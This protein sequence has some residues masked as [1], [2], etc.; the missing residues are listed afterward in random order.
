MSGKGEE[1]ARTEF[2]VELS[3]CSI[4]EDEIDAALIVEIAVEAQDVLV[5]EM[6][7][8]LYLSPQLVLYT[9]LGQLR[10]EQHLERHD[11]VRFLLAGEV[12]VA[13]LAAAQG[14]ADVKV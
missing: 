12:D 11:V 4:L 3:L 14:L 10:L 8:D 1:G 2:L 5:A 7:L 6:R 13:E 9:R